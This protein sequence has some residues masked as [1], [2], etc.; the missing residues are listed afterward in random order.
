MQKDFFLENNEPRD[1]ITNDGL[2]RYYPS[3]FFDHQNLFRK[4]ETDIPWKQDQITLYGKTHNI[5]RLQC[6]MGEQELSYTYSNIKL[7]ASPWSEIVLDIKKQIEQLTSKKF[8]AV[9]CNFYRNGTD[10]VSWHSD[11]EPEL[12]KNP[13]IASVSFGEAREFELKHKHKKEIEKVR[14]T[15][16]SG[17]LLLMSGSLQHNWVHQIVKTK[18]Q[19][20]PRIN[21]TYRFFP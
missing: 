14:L 20:S 9:L 11:D 8:N 12:G 10:Y 19:M 5:P 18:K 6:F 4:L 1:I 16:E 17:S 15:L 3:V 7:I 21:L 13:L 2:A